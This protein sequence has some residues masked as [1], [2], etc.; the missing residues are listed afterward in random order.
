[1]VRGRGIRVFIP[2]R[3]TTT[4]TTT[5]MA[6]IPPWEIEIEFPELSPE[7]PMSLPLWWELSSPY[8]FSEARGK[9]L[10]AVCVAIL[11]S[12]LGYRYGLD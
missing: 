1:M 11:S 7:A 6:I 5:M 10:S 4:T 2:P 9:A 12:G 3:R 8:G